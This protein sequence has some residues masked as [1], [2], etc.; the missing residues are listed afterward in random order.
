LN[1]RQERL[2]VAR[3]FEQ[4]SKYED[5]EA[6]YQPSYKSPIGV[7]EQAVFFLQYE[8]QIVQVPGKVIVQNLLILF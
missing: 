1:R 7:S 5:E 8:A 3:L 2:T 6:Q 4:Q